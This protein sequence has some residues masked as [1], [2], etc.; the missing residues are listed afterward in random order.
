MHWAP[1]RGKLLD[2]D[3]RDLLAELANLHYSGRI[4]IELSKPRPVVETITRSRHFVEGLLGG[5]PQGRP[6]IAA[7][8]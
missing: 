7:S 8:G 5:E 6:L 3:F 2:E 1:Q 4:S